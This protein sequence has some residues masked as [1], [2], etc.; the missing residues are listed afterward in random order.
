M[1]KGAIVI[2]LY[3]TTISLYE[4]WKLQFY[5]LSSIIGFCYLLIFIK[6]NNIASIV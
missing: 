4:E 3:I 1:V 5:L 2:H 6:E